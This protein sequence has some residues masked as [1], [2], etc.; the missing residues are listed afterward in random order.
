[1]LTN[2]VIKLETVI[3]LQVKVNSTVCFVDAKLIDCL[4]IFN[5]DYQLK[6]L[7]LSQAKSI[8]KIF[9]QITFKISSRDAVTKSAL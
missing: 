4:L 3:Q 2:C 8:I 5:Y 6:V 1:M 9:I 7:V